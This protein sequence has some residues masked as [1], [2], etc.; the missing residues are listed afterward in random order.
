MFGTEDTCRFQF[1]SDFVPVFMSVF[2]IDCSFYL[3]Y[4]GSHQTETKMLDLYVNEYKQK[5]QSNIL[6]V[7]KGLLQY[8]YLA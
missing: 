1:S 7:L 3:K 8:N 2:F 5:S 4:C 6:I